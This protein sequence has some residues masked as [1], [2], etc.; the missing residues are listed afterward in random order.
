MLISCNKL[1]LKWDDIRVLLAHG[2][3]GSWQVD[4][5]SLDLGHHVYAVG[6]A[7]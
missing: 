1:I 2:I 3:G 6:D 4:H 5:S 7:L